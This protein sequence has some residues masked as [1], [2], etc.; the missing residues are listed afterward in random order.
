MRIP[1]S[2][3]STD[4]RSKPDS[5]SATLV[6]GRGEHRQDR[7]EDLKADLAQPLLAARRSRSRPSRVRSPE[8][9]SARRASSPDARRLGDRIHH[10]PGQRA[11]SQLAPVSSRRRN[12][13]SGSVARPNSSPSICLR[14]RRRPAA[15]GLLDLARSRGRRRRR[16]A[17]AR[18]PGG[19]RRRRRSRSRRRRG[20]GAAL[21]EQAD[22]DRRPRRFEARATARRG[23]RPCASERWSRR[24]RARRSR[25][26][27]GASCNGR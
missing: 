27:P 3:Y 7:P 17:T 24:P 20:P 5:A 1:S 4:A 25:H 14:R 15:R 9:I 18:P 23:S 19:A 10:H 13:P 8:S 2:L 12:A 6:A 11:L 22:A 16:S 26:P 21:R